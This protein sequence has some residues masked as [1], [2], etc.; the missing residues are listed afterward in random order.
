MASSRKEVTK[1]ILDKFNE[2][3]PGNPNIKITEDFLNGLSETAFKELMVKLANKEDVLPFY[4]PNIKSKPLDCTNLLKMCDKLNIS[5][6]QRLKKV[7]RISGI[8]YI[9]PHVY[10]VLPVI[11]RR[12]IQTTMKGKSVMEDNRHTD[13]YTGQASGPSAVV[14]I[15]FPEL[16]I[17]DSMGHQPIVD[18]LVRHRGGN[19]SS[20]KFMKRKLLDSGRVSIAELEEVG[21]RATSINTA[22]AWFLAAHIENNI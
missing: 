20:F 22:R 3:Q 1:Y 4:A 15:T 16:A 18:E 5:V 2:M 19:E 21:T 7:D 8:E 14:K 17:L 9:T 13:V 6:F 11:T 10:M 12:Q